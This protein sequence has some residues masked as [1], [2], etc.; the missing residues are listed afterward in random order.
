[1]K[2]NFLFIF[3]TLLMS[4][5]SSALPPDAIM[6]KITV[7]NAPDAPGTVSRER[8]ATCMWLI[9]QDLKMES[10]ELPHILVMHVTAKDAASA[11]VTETAVRHNSG[12]KVG[13]KG[14]YEFWI[15]GEPTAVEYSAAIYNIL[16]NRTGTRRE[17]KERVSI[18]RRALRY[19]QA[20]ISA[21]GE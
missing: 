20:T 10:Q 7:L 2:R 1:M 17:D 4:L 14:Y 18:M 15:V 16:E 11:G 6:Q 21:V 5:S 3:L 13:A 8:L 9:A 19:L 12:A